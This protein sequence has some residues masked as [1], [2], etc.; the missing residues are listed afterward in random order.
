VDGDLVGVRKIRRGAIVTDD[1][2]TIRKIEDVAIDP[3][4]GG[5]SRAVAPFAWHMR[6]GQL[7]D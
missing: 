6:R 1:L 2:L 3:H 4:L 7:S 5:T